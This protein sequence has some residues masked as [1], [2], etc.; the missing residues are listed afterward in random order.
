MEVQFIFRAAFLFAPMDS[1]P[2][3]M[4]FAAYLKKYQDFYEISMK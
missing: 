4:F 2:E 1:N 3:L